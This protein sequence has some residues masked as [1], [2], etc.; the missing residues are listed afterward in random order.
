MQDTKTGLSLGNQAL[1]PGGKSGFRLIVSDEEITLASHLRQL[2]QSYC[3]FIAAK[4][5]WTR[6]PQTSRITAH[7]RA[8]GIGMG[9]KDHEALR[10]YVVRLLYE[11]R[12]SRARRS[13][14]FPL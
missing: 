7:V 9:K 5:R 1:P 4:N 14:D 3:V 13:R 10:R 8:E 12:P 11:A 2:R 6:T